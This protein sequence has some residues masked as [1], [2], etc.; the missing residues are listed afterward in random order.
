MFKKLLLVGAL[1]TGISLTG[2]IGSV[3]ASVPSSWSSCYSSPVYTSNNGKL[4]TQYIVKNSK[5]FPNTYDSN[6]IRWYFKGSNTLSCKE[7][8]KKVTKY[9]AKYE[10][11]KTKKS[12]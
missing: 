2:V 5:V 3:S 7:K 1:A 11:R 12:H 6:G 8:S 9:V 10:G 4:Y